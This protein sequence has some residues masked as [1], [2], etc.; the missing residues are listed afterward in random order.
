MNSENIHKYIILSLN[1]FIYLKNKNA[2][3]KIY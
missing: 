3:N 1:N 2:I